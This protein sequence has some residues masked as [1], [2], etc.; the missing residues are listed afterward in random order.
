MTIPVFTMPSGHYKKLFLRLKG[1]SHIPYPPPQGVPKN[2]PSITPIELFLVY[3]RDKFVYV[4][5]FHY[6][7]LSINVKNLKRIQ[8]RCLLFFVLVLKE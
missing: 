3:A 8:F 5:Y 6:F 2:L 7:S 4:V 1:D